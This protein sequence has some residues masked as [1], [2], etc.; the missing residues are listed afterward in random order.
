MR[1]FQVEHP[2]V[3]F[4]NY[5]VGATVTEFG[6]EKAFEFAGDWLARDYIDIEHV[7]EP[8]DHGHAIVSLLALPGR[9]VVDNMGLRPRRGPASPPASL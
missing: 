1:S 9:A 3:G 8:E 5:V 7:L 6:D 2:T 4:T